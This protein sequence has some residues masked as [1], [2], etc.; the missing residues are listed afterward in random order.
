MKTSTEDRKIE[1]SGVTDSAKFTINA[2]GKAF[3]ALID[4]LYSNKIKSIIRELWTNAYDSH[5]DAGKPS[6]PFECHLPSFLNPEF[7]VR[8]FGVSLSHEDVLGLYSTIFESTKEDT[9]SQV[10]KWGLGSKSP[11]A[12]TDTFTV[13][14][15][16]DGT[17]RQYSAYIGE[18]G[19]PIIALMDM[20]PSGELKGLQISFPV[21]SDDI[22][23][24]EENADEV[25]TGFD[26]KPTLVGTIKSLNSWDNK[27]VFEGTNW[28]IFNNKSYS[29]GHK[30]QARQGCVLYPID[31]ALIPE[32]KDKMNNLSNLNM[33]INFEIGDLDISVSRESLSYDDHT[34]KNIAKGLNIMQNELAN[35]VLETFADC[36]TL[37][38]KRIAAAKYLT[39]N[40]S[41][42]TKFSNNFRIYL[43]DST[44]KIVSK[45]LKW[46][47][48]PISARFT[49]RAPIHTDGKKLTF[50]R[51]NEYNPSTNIRHKAILHTQV[52]A[53]DM[54]RFFVQDNTKKL[55]YSGGRI[56]AA[57]E[58]DD[59]CC[60]GIWIVCDPKSYA[61]KRFIAQCGNPPVT[62]V[63]TLAKPEIESSYVKTPVQVK[64]LSYGGSFE[65]TSIDDSKTYFYINTNRNA[66]L[67]GDHENGRFVAPN[68][69]CYAL[70]SLKDEGFIKKDEPVIV[71]PS[72][73]KKT[74]DTTNWIHFPS[75]V[76]KLIEDN[77]DVAEYHHY[78]KHS[79]FMMDNSRAL[80]VGRMLVDFGIEV[81]ETSAMKPIMEKIIEADEFIEAM[82]P[83]CKIAKEMMDL[84]RISFSLVDNPVK[85]VESECGKFCN[86]AEVN[87]P[88]IMRYGSSHVDSSSSIKNIRHAVLY[89]LSVDNATKEDTK[90][91]EYE[92]EEWIKIDTKALSSDEQSE[93]AIAA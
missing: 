39:H 25:S 65:P 33:I 40:N 36:T 2:N 73:L 37:W 12:Y 44:K 64:K 11:F 58:A 6:E 92:K 18:D 20:K 27:V 42:S 53:T 74:I 76:E 90:L 9:N 93:K 62:F 26:I 55:S 34:Q 5:I 29:Y 59:K 57:I 31:M 19:I 81:S 88:L 48:K 61:Y 50:M 86:I 77:F 84:L 21:D 85:S 45:T 23:E 38:E 66:T 83:F 56:K 7:R 54:L 72:S 51:V 68:T 91:E 24:F 70:K 79:T 63:D 47:G 87:Y 8:D 71:I 10:G 1:T 35:I 60:E 13:T 52:T 17:Q 22:D 89:I 4:G 78:V 75:F 43:P 32:I 69:A 16:L 80:T 67:L 49:V 14:T 41:Y 30:I 46:K 15:W 28:K 82:N 3:K